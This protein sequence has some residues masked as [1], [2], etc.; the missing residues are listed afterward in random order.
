MASLSLTFSDLYK[1]VSV[2][3]G[4][5]PTPQGPDLDACRKYVNEGYRIFLMGQDPSTQR[6]YQW[7]FL[8]PRAQ[9]ALW[10]SVTADPRRTVTG[11]LAAGVTTCTATQ[12]VF[13]PSMVG[14]GMTITGVGTFT[15]CEVDSPTSIKVI[16]DAA[17]GA[18]TFAVA[19]EGA[20]TLPAGFGCLLD[21]PTYAPP[22]PSVRLEARSPQYIRQLHAAGGAWGG[23]P[24]Y[25]AVTPV[26]Q[27][28]AIVNRYELLTWPHCDASYTLRMRYRVEPDALSDDDQL[29]LGGL[30]HAQTILQ[31]GLMVAE[32]R[33]NDTMGLHTER[34]GELMAAS[35]DLDSRNKASNLGDISDGH[36]G[37]ANW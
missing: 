19:S 1:E 36:N 10:A 22:G 7:S 13:F 3:L 23:V 30:Q 25:Y 4:L 5:G 6:A 32:Q 11:V 15:I 17:C 29:P 26:A 33:H 20:Y 35:I 21:D 34:F 2:F 27:L 14:R 24:R 37:L 12:N 28:P 16:G 31:A 9:L 18:S 8:A